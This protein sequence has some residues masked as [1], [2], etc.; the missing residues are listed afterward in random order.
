MIVARRTPF[1]PLYQSE[2]TGI[3]TVNKP[4]CGVAEVE[5]ARAVTRAGDGDAGTVSR[6]Q[7]LRM[8]GW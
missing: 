2:E 6:C 1:H 7:L 5:L 4:V 3:L 8:V